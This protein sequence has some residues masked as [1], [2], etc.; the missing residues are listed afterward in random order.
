MAH[1]ASHERE[2]A[3]RDVP[4]AKH[5]PCLRVHRRR[6]GRVFGS[7]A[8]L[9][10]G[11]SFDQFGNGEVDAGF[12]CGLPYVQLARQTP[13]P[14]EV[15]A[16]P[17]IRGDRYAGRPIYFSDVIV[18]RDSPICAFAD[19]R[20]RS[21]A[22]NDPHS[23][24]GYNVTRHHL[25]TMG[26]IRGFFGRVVEAGFRQKAIRMVATGEVDTAAIDSQVL[27]I[28]LCDHSALAAELRVIEVLGPS[29]IQPV[30]AARHLSVHLKDALRTVL[31]RIGNDTAGRAELERGFV[32]RFVE[33]SDDVHDDARGMLLAGEN[34][35]FITLA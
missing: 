5:A 28:E 21:W 26:E 27:A 1:N 29:T 34:A 15:L 19:L 24:S 25:L 20:G 30:V 23:H 18:R 22:Y 9:V 3:H 17:V 6:I 4:G 31:L 11:T 12:I 8:E 7:G 32:D 2:A 13:A 16:A 35:G 14:V 10:V 33:V